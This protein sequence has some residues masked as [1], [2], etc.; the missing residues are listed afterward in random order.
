MLC[1]SVFALVVSVG[2]GIAVPNAA[3]AL[4]QPCQPLLVGHSYSCSVNFQ[5][6]GLSTVLLSFTAALA[7]P[8]TVSTKFDV[9]KGGIGYGCTCAPSGT[10]GNTRFDSSKIFYCMSGNGGSGILVTGKVSG[11]GLK[12]TNLAI[13]DQQGASS[14]GAC[15]QVS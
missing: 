15:Q 9:Q 7:P 14:L 5:T 10:F 3:H 4:P 13:T 8:D 12:I 6:G 11:N 1:R 2:L